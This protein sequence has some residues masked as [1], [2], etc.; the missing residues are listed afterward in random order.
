MQTIGLAVPGWDS[1]KQEYVDLDCERW[2]RENKIRE[3]GRENGKQEYP[4]SEAVQPDEM[5]RK[6]LAWVNQ[7]GKGCYAAVHEYLVQKR[8][9]LEREVKEGMAPIRY[10]VEGMR[11]EGIQDLTDQATEAQ[12]SLRQ[13]K[14]E[15]R[16]AWSALEKF[17]ERAN[18]QR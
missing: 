8:E 7:R 17:Q 6:I 14:H 12:T 18:L 9:E 10:R 4:P 5:Y 15:A 11:D 1:A 16:E 3:A 13:S 2:I